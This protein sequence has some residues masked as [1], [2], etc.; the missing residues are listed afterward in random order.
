MCVYSKYIYMHICITHIIYHTSSNK[1]IFRPTGPAIAGCNTFAGKVC[2]QDDLDNFAKVCKSLAK[3]DCGIVL[4]T[5]DTYMCLQVTTSNTRYISFHRY[6]NSGCSKYT[7][8][9]TL[10][11]DPDWNSG[12]FEFIAR[13][14][15]SIEAEGKQLVWSEGNALSCGGKD[16]VSNSFAAS[17]WILDNLFESAIRG[18]KL[19]CGA[20][21][22][23]AW[24]YAHTHRHTRARAHGYPDERA[25]GSGPQLLP[26][27][28]RQGRAGHGLARLLRHAGLPQVS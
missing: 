3:R 27:P 23:A 19:V 11:S 21:Q 5:R 18:V 28:R 6:G 22:Q 8:A 16:G 12:D 2:W 20:A 15:P 7:N 4:N 25:F 10:L 1:G 14:A 13:L 24:P 17:L 9:R 26:V